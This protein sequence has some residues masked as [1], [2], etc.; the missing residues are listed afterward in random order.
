M[1][2]M[3]LFNVHTNINQKLA[4]INC[5]ACSREKGRSDWEIG[6]LKTLANAR[7]EASGLKEDHYQI[8]ECEHCKTLA[9]LSNR[10]VDERINKVK[11]LVLQKREELKE[12]ETELRKLYDDL[13][14]TL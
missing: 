11:N 8:I 14:S 9:V 10:I 5:G 7:R 3:P 4:E 2:E 6:R 12:L 13:T 1:I